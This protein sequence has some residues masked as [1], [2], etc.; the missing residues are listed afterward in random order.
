LAQRRDGSQ[1]SV[2]REKVTQRRAGRE[3]KEYI[4]P[5]KK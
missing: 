4:D 1:N 3:K 5:G 2:L